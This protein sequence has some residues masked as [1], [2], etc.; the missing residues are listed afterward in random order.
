[1]KDEQ[2]HKN[3]SIV[4]RLSKL[5]MVSLTDAELPQAAAQISAMKKAFEI[6]SAK[7]VSKIEPLFTPNSELQLREDQVEA[8]AGAAEALEQVPELQGK[9]VKVPLV[10]G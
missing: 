4:D 7:D 8:W 3:Q 5:A 9:L 1:M 10:L 6:I 2:K